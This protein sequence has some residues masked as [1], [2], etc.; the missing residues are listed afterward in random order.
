MWEEVSNDREEIRRKSVAWFSSCS[1]TL[2]LRHA[3]DDDV[4]RVKSNLVNIDVIVKDKKGKYI[5]DLKAEDF[6][7]TEN[8]VAAEDRI[9]RRATFKNRNSA[10]PVNSRRAATAHARN[11]AAQLRLACARLANHR[12]HKSETGS[13][14]RDQ[15]CSRTNDGR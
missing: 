15:V 6:T 9:L 7:I 5:S 4:V 2:H 11:C 3:Q 10:N 13:R 14:R 12:R 8:G 1:L